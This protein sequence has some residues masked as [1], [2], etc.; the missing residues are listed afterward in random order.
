MA[1]AFI[2]FCLILCCCQASDD[3]LLTDDVCIAADDCDLSLR[4]L[5]G[6]RLITADQEFSVAKPDASRLRWDSHFFVSGGE[7]E[8]LNGWLR[9]P[10]MHDSA[11]SEFETSPDVCLR[12]RMVPARKQ[13]AK[14]G[15]LLVHCGGPGSGRG[16]VLDMLDNLDIDKDGKIRDAFDIWSIDQ[17][18][19]NPFGGPGNDQDYETAEYWGE[20]PPPCPFS[21][22]DGK[23]IQPFPRVFC[24]EMLAGKYTK[25]ELTKMLG[26]LNNDDTD[27]WET[28][29]KPI[30]DK[31]DIP[32]D[33]NVGVGAY[34]ESYVRWF[35]RLVKLE[36]SLC[37]NADRY[38][39]T[40]P[41]GRQYQV[42]RFAG[43]EDLV[44]DI[45]IFRQAVGA[46]K[47]SI[48]GFSYGTAVAGTY[49]TVF[50]AFSNRIIMD[51]VVSPDPDV[52]K[53]GNAFAKGLSAVWNGMM[54]DCD[55]TEATPNIS[56]DDLC[57]AAPGAE[58]KA[59][60]VL[61][62]KTQPKKA[63]ELYETAQ[64]ALFKPDG[65]LAP[66]LMA[67][68][69]RLYSGEESETCPD[70][71][72]SD[73]TAAALLEVKSAGAVN[74]TKFPLDSFNLAIQ[75]VVMGTDTAGRLNEEAVVAWWKKIKESDPIGAPWALKWIVAIST[76]PADA[77]PVPPLGS[78]SIQPVIIGNLHD[79]NTA[80]AT[81]QTTKKMF[82]NGAIMTWQGYG[83]CL[84]IT[85]AGSE[86]LEKY[87]KSLTENKLPE[88]TNDVAK[89]ACMSL[90]MKYL[91]S[92]QLPID[93][94]TCL[95][96][97][98]LKVGSA[99]AASALEVLMGSR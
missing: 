88:Y 13:P 21:D 64:A 42:L 37:Y 30:L 20:E 98:T 36:H 68:I 72:F 51:G 60:Q 48:Y 75:A 52:T 62:D 27:A 95:V 56:K 28:Y 24:D 35:Y 57:P 6:Q 54:K 90:V 82:P 94:H 92:E 16:C 17:R 40:G 80:Y 26:G 34:D 67:C 87:Q 23:A 29:I 85:K 43:T 25:A 84:R 8:V 44:Q 66:V 77:R 99:A 11:L 45:D 10:L 4:Q 41:S 91:D 14:N 79:P 3:E 12:V 15:P 70:S 63:A 2:G 69:A 74:R 7:T 22:D 50:P 83:H 9:V 32:V 55:L 39:L 78:S 93:G 49:A 71:L 65:V 38:Q 1:F 76:W 47:M 19:V 53:R 73:T 58:S 96:P 18:G 33:A 59:L 46:E 61:M 5:R 81:A 31:Q 97:D 86:L 89:Y